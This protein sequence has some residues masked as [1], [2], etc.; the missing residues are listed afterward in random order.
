[1]VLLRTEHDRRGD[2]RIYN[3]LI[4]I[5]MKLGD[6]DMAFGLIQLMGQSSTVQITT[7]SVDIL[8]KV[9]DTVGNKSH[10]QEAVDL[11]SRLQV[12]RGMK[13]DRMLIDTMLQT[14]FSKQVYTNILTLTRVAIR[15]GMYKPFPLG[16]A[17]SMCMWDLHNTIEMDACFLLAEAFDR[18]AVHASQGVV[19][20]VVI[21]TG[22]GLGSKNAPVL[23]YALTSDS[24]SSA[25]PGWTVETSMASYEVHMDIDDESVPPVYSNEPVTTES[26]VAGTQ[27]AIE[28]PLE[29]SESN[30][31]GSL[32]FVLS[33]D[34]SDHGPMVSGE[35]HAFYPAGNDLLDG[36]EGPSSS[37]WRQLPPHPGYSRWAPGSFVM[38]GTARTYFM[39][40]YDRALRNLYSDLWMIDLSGLF[41]SLDEEQG[42]VEREIQEETST[43]DIGAG[44][45]IKDV[46]S[47]SASASPSMPT[48][49]SARFG[50]FMAT[51]S[52]VVVSAVLH[53][54]L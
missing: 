54:S 42:D 29:G 44:A 9:C 51:T 49:S 37:W 5:C 19:R 21:V 8:L 23:R 25:D 26:R 41:L 6:A 34:G 40:G 16:T 45:D 52:V 28:L 10:V 53:F 14:C 46:E 35:L 3:A 27:F 48:S 36:P 7:G 24:N 1:M 30:L 50:I 13:A 22:K 43:G 12:E 33:G 18:A 38:R 39:G 17:G 20:D 31:K 32:G 47:P 4:K 11:F 15:I 2:H